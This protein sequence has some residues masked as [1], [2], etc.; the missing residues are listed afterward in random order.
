MMGTA[1]DLMGFNMK[2]I[3]GELEH[4]EQPGQSFLG[5]L[6]RPVERRALRV[7]V[8]DD[9]VLA[10]RGPGPG[11]MQRQGGLADTALVVEER[12]DHGGSPPPTASGRLQTQLIVM[13]SRHESARS[14][15][16]IPRLM[17]RWRSVAMV[18][19]N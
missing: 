16:H 19:P 18:E 11:H 17:E 13:R 2:G 5:A 1:G 10:L 8:E 12:D 3:A 15:V 9:N 6:F 7:R 14:D 4:I